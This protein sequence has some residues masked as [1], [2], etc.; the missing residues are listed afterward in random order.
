[1]INYDLA[2][3]QAETQLVMK[4][5]VR[6][7]VLV[8]LLVNAGCMMGP[9]FQ[10]PVMAPPDTYRLDDKKTEAAVD[11]KWWE[12]F[13][14]PVLESLVS[15]A[16]HNNKDLMIA[17]SRIEEARASLGFTKADMYPRLDINAGASRGNYVGGRKT[18]TD[19]SF[20]IAPT[21]SWEID[22]WGKFRRANE[23]ALAEL[24][25]SEYSL[26]TVQISLI[27]E[28]VAT[29]FL[30]LD[31]RQRLEISERT[32]ESRQKSL[33]IIQKRFDKGI[34]PE[35]DVNQ[36]QIQRE[37]AAAST[38][39]FRRLIAKTEHA[40][41]ILLGRFPGEVQT[42]IDLFGQT[43]P[44]GIPVGLPS[45]L[46]ERRPDI[47]QA[48]NLLHAETARIGVA[49]ALRFPTIS[50]TGIFGFA[51]TELD[52]LISEGDAWSVGGGL[53]APIFDFNKNKLRVAIQEE[54]TKQAFYLYQNTV[55]LAFKEVE[56]A[57][58]EVHTYDDEI[59]AVERQ[60]HAA[61]NA[62]NLSKMRY[63]Q[64]VTSYLEVLETE[65]QLFSAGLDFSTIKQEYLNAYVKLYKALGGGW[66]SKDEEEQAQNQVGSQ[67]SNFVYP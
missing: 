30:L 32:L 65:R 47:G 34:I 57:L 43:V 24:M 41:G 53:F 16:L 11:L 7:V 50:L 67:E 58:S 20:F 22:F 37:I 56:D 36:A 42:G 14:D 21:V 5:L 10:R 62:A 44:P 48:V 18:G 9:D 46:L 19:N 49:E 61:K 63:D 55:L 54:R 38:P 2:S 27:S 35:I 23:A 25:A 33:D 60:Y 29:Y 59:A 13:K 17:T 15:T 64:G 1:M 3:L 6:L 66:L 39:F 26:R 52:E 45:S 31:Y 51:S 8:V 12:L 40:L 4:T 28:V